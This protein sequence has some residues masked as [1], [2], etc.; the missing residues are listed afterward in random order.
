MLTS[1]KGIRVN[2]RSAAIALFS[3]MMCAQAAQAASKLSSVQGAT[4]LYAL[5]LELCTT[6]LSYCQEF[7]VTEKTNHIY[8]HDILS[9]TQTG[10]GLALI[11]A[12]ESDGENALTYKA[13]C[14]SK[15]YSAPII[16]TY[17][18]S[19]DFM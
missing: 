19:K 7:P 5:K 13:T 8:M 16:N 10:K 15:S 11:K 1:Q 14:S 2:K 9:C 3:T 4:D 18:P 17:T 12:N 6:D